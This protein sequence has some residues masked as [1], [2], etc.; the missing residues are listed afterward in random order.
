[1]K[2]I[3]KVTKVQPAD[4]KIKEEKSGGKLQSSHLTTFL[5][6]NGNANT[7]ASSNTMFLNN[8]SNLLN[9]MTQHQNVSSSQFDNTKIQQKL[10]LD[11]TAK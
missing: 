7:T 3:L 6:S 5:K 9:N 8:K 11:K 1:M 2:K 10:K 4:L